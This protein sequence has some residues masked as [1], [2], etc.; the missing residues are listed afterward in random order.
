MVIKK[1][2]SLGLAILFFVLSFFLKTPVSAQ[3]TAATYTG[4]AASD[5]DDM[6]I[7]IHPNDP[8]ASTIIGSDKSANKIFVYDLAGNV[9]QTLDTAGQP[10][11]ID[12]R[13]N[14]P[15]SGN[16]VD[17]VV[18]NQRSNGYKLLVYQIDS[19]TGSLSQV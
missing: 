18:V 6:A 17:I 1:Q 12:I 10:G 19:Q 9:I 2:Y 4:P 8:S 3:T 11:N 16:L 13:Y 5:Q 14:F 7:W 15:L